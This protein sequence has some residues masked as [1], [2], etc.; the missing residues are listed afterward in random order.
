MSN[1][2][3]YPKFIKRCHNEEDIKGLYLGKF[4]K[5]TVR[6]LS[7]QHK[8]VSHYCW[9]IKI[10]NTQISAKGMDYLIHPYLAIGLRLYRNSYEY[11][12]FKY[13]TPCKVVFH[14]I[15]NW[16]PVE[17]YSTRFPLDTLYFIKLPHDTL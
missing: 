3:G 5:L 7:L 4:Y 2:Q 8:C 9:E 11:Q 13:L 14:E 15:P 16:H 6:L 10:K 1:S 12:K 17:L